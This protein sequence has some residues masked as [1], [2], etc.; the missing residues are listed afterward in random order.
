[1]SLWNR[2]GR[3]CRYRPK[4]M[5]PP[6][7]VIALKELEEALECSG[8]Q[9]VMKDPPIFVCEKFHELCFKCHG[10]LT[11]EKKPCPVCQGKLTGQRN[12]RLEMIVEKFPKVACIN[13][14]R[15][16]NFMRA[17]RDL[18]VEHQVLCPQRLAPCGLCDE[19]DEVLLPF[20]KEPQL[21]ELASHMVLGHFAERL[22][23][24]FRFGAKIRTQVPRIGGPTGTN[25]VPKV[26][27]LQPTTVPS[28]FGR[29]RSAAQG[30]ADK[31]DFVFEHFFGGF[32]ATFAPLP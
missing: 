1:M 11:K 29:N 10:Q 7:P 4:V 27:V 9:K 2:C 20:F 30:G 32:Q 8:C 19:G 18:V 5:A 24:T 17:C 23:G 22:P 12:K 6:P 13:V 15:G 3:V 21:S 26:L 28:I 25:Y 14:G 31:A 16:C